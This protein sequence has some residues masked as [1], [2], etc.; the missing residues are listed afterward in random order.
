MGTA[1]L[2]LKRA[3]DAHFLL[4]LFDVVEVVR[5]GDADVGAGYGGVAGNNLV[6]RQA[7]VLI[8]DHDIE[9]AYTVARNPGLTVYAGTPA[10][11]IF[12]RH[13]HRIKYKLGVKVWK[14]IKG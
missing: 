10:Y 4:N 14:A 6:G 12:T 7:L 3:F 11:T 8:A 13:E 2:L 1:E 5:E 9:H